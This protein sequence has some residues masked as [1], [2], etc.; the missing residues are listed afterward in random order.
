MGDPRRFDEFANLVNHHF[1]EMKNQTVYDVAGGKGYLNLSL[2]ERGFKN[3]ITFEPNMRN[4]NNRVTGIQY[5]PQLFKYDSAPR[6]A[7]LV[8]GMHPDQASDH[9]ISMRIY[10][11]FHL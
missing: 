4:R 7:R 2:S 8:I 6:E 5:R 10:I 11:K 9:I 3:I 1:G